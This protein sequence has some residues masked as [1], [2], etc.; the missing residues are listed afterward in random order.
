MV[1]NFSQVKKNLQTLYKQHNINEKSEQDWLF[2][3]VLKLDR[4][5]LFTV[6]EITKKE[7][8]DLLK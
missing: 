2:S 1:V 6:E 7:I 8:L 5:K 3:H 4:A